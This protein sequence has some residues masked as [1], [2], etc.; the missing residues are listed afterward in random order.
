MYPEDCGFFIPS[1]AKCR[2]GHRRSE[3]GVWYMWLKIYAI[4]KLFQ[5]VED[6]HCV[7]TGHAYTSEIHMHSEF[8][9][10]KKCQLGGE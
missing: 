8:S 3:N 4:I 10:V 1:I 6:I 9:L 5:E 2:Q 7:F